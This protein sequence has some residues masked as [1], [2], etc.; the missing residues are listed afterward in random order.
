MHIRPLRRGDLL[1]LDQI[2]PA[3][4]S[5]GYLDVQ[6]E[7][8]GLDTTFRLV[9]KRFDT[10]FTKR[11]GYGYS[12][13]EL[14]HTD[15]RLESGQALQLVVEAEGRLVGVL[16]V[17][18]E[19][20]RGTA[21][22]WALFID[23]GWRGRGLGTQLLTRARDWARTQKLRAVVLE[24]Q[25]NNLPALHFYRKQGFQIAAVDPFFYT[26]HDIE[27]HEVALFLYQPLEIGPDQPI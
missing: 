7:R 12:T 23:Q 5:D 6:I 27:R 10:P 1:A 16:E 4:T 21:L 9:E 14:T 22:I 15:F 3:F 13:E 2:D 25:S 24:T 18:A 20:W 26:N 8:Q 11:E 19:G 17:E